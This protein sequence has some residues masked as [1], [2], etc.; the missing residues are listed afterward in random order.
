[1]R[2]QTVER[3]PLPT[4]GAHGDTLPAGLVAITCRVCGHPHQTTRPTCAE[5]GSPRLLVTMLC[6]IPKPGV[7]PPST[8]TA[9]L[10]AI[11]IGIAVVVAILLACISVLR[12]ETAIL[13][14]E[15]S[16]VLSIA[17]AIVART[18]ARRVAPARWQRFSRRLRRFATAFATH[19]LLPLIVLSLTTTIIVFTR[20]AEL[21][22]WTS[23]PVVLLV[24]TLYVVCRTAI[25]GPSFLIAFFQRF[26]PRRC[27]WQQAPLRA[28]V[29]VP[30][31]D[32]VE[33]RQADPRDPR[34][35][36][37]VAR[38]GWIGDVQIRTTSAN[39]IRVATALRAIIAAQRTLPPAELAPQFDD[40]R[41]DAD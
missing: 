11:G 25:E 13:L 40:Q 5:C 29:P 41:S 34:C 31:S 12:G 37:F 16:L 23:I 20:V 32:I 38:D 33:L 8:A 6:S 22:Y 10:L 36:H 2:E 4:L 35:F 1:M 21:V 26:V 39:A 17:A 18:A 30:L 14:A 24:V 19:V 3:P 28:R 27:A 9:H 7:P 15:A